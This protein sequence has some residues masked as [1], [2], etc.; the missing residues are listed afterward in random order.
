MN[1]DLS[2][3]ELADAAGVTPRTVRYYIQIGLLPPAGT[4]PGAHYGEDYVERIRLIKKLQRSH[5]PLANIR[6]ELA[7]LDSQQVRQVLA[8]DSALSKAAPGTAIEYVRSQLAHTPQSP[9]SKNFL[10]HFLRPPTADLSPMRSNWE[11]ISLDPDIEIH[12]QRPLSRHKNHLLDD[13]VRYSQNLLK[14]DQ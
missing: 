2:L 12:V 11:R 7:D 14:E 13:I 1:E 9:I 6:E 8:A 10:V 5:L 3:T 4:G